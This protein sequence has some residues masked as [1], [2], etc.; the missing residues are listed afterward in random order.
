[1]LTTHI[2]DSLGP[3]TIWYYKDKTGY[4]ATCW[5]GWQDG[6][7]TTGDYIWNVKNRV[8]SHIKAKH[9]RRKQKSDRRLYSD[10]D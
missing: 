9:E 10:H 8:F 7:P 4:R 6:S 5:C 1:M 3:V 2:V